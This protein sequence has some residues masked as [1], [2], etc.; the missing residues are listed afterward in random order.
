[1][2]NLYRSLA[3]TFT[4]LDNSG[5]KWYQEVCSPKIWS[6]LGHLWGQTE[7]HRAISD[8]VSTASEN[9][10]CAT[11]PDNLLNCKNILL[12]KRFL[13]ISSLNHPYFHPSCLIFPT[14]PCCK[15]PVFV[16]LVISPQMREKG[17]GGSGKM[18]LFPHNLLF[19]KDLFPQLHFTRQMLQPWQSLWP[20]IG[21]LKVI[22]T[23]TEEIQNW[24]LK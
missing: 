18:M 21:L 24:M 4:S 22:S 11:F 14:M 6:A 2:N 10:D 23:G 3:K 8:W 17:E 5:Y 15:A 7:I 13:F 9:G 12:G 1:M 20:S 19:L 16:T